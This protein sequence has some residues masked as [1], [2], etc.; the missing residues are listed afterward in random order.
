MRTPSAQG[1]RAF[2]HAVHVDLDIL[3]AAER[4]A[5][6]QARRVGQAHALLHQGDGQAALVHAFEFGQL[7]RAVDAGDLGGIGDLVGH[8]GH[9][10]LDGELHDVG[11]VVLA[12]GVLVV[13]PGQPGA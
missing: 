10:A 11:E 2:K 3:A 5:H 7:H 6:V 1:D 12:L 4:A 8:D 13:E 9:T